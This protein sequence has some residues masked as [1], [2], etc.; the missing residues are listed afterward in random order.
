MSPS[1]EDFDARIQETIRNIDAAVAEAEASSAR[2][3]QLQGS[4]GLSR[5]VG[6]RYFDKVSPAERQKAE[7]ELAALKE[8]AERDLSHAAAPA[9]SVKPIPPGRIRI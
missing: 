4:V 3:D 9:K 5:G 1:E 7:Q 8:E 2:L 6:K